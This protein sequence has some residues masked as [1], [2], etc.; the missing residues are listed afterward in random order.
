MARSHSF[1]P[2][3]VAPA[4]IDRESARRDK[5]E[6]T[7]RP[8]SQGETDIH[9]GKR[10]AETEAILKARAEERAAAEAEQQQAEEA[11]D[12]HLGLTEEQVTASP[13]PPASGAVASEVGMPGMAREARSGGGKR[14]QRRARGAAER[15]DSPPLGAMPAEELPPTAEQVLAETP[16]ELLGAFRDQ[17][18]RSLR[19]VGKRRASSGPR[20]A[21]WPGSRWR[22]SGSSSAWGA[23]GS[24]ARPAVHEGCSVLHV[25]TGRM[26]STPE[27]RPG[28]ADLLVQLAGELS[29][30]V[31]QHIALA[32]L[33]LGETAR[34][35]GLGVARIAAFAPLVLVGYAFLNAALALWLG[36]W[37]PLA[38][39]V[40]LVG[41]LNVAGGSPGGRPRRAVLPPSGARR[42]GPGARADGP[43]A[44]SGPALGTERPCRAGAPAMTLSRSGPRSEAELR[45]EIERAR[46]QVVDTAQALR[47]QLHDIWDV[48]HWVARRPGLTLGIAFAAGLWL[49]IRRR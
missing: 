13:G 23:R 9:Y 8:A 43:G 20:A 44:R 39:A 48:R 14:R 7:A 42:L 12:L 15:H 29:H 30:L 49:G 26:H 5:Q 32:K 41:L 40:A 21:R 16:A 28:T 17:A 11:P 2:E 46:T 19:G 45:E 6:L 38:G 34:R 24:D 27:H 10:F 4:D 25:S 36:Q 22:G 1:E 47:R 18:I 37:L 33:E 35:T 31:S 3:T